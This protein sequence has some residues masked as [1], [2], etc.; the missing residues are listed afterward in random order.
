MIHILVSES[1]DMGS[2]PIST[3]NFQ[4]QLRQDP[5]YSSSHL[6]KKKILSLYLYSFYL[7]CKVFRTWSIFY[8]CPLGGGGG[9]FVWFVLFFVVFF[10][11]NL[12][13][14]SRN[15]EYATLLFLL[16]VFPSSPTPSFWNRDHLPFQPRIQQSELKRGVNAQHLWRQL[17]AWF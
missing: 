16:R 8:V 2:S 15:L 7:D 14:A 3:T 5:I 11:R 13:Q 4:R 9:L 1:R 17:R 12:S 10:F 6:K